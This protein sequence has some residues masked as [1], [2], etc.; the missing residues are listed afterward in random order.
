MTNGHTKSANDLLLFRVEHGFHLRIDA[1]SGGSENSSSATGPLDLQSLSQRFLRK[2]L[3]F[4]QYLAYMGSLLPKQYHDLLVGYFFSGEYVDDPVGL[5]RDTNVN[6]AELSILCQTL[7]LA[8]RLEDA[9]IVRTVERGI[10]ELT[11]AAFA[12]TKLRRIASVENLGQ[13]LVA[14][15]APPIDRMEELTDFS[16]ILGSAKGQLVRMFGPDLFTALQQVSDPDF[17]ITDAVAQRQLRIC[18][19]W[20]CTDL[21]AQLLL[22]RA[23]RDSDQ[24]N[25]PARLLFTNVTFSES[26]NESTR[27]LQKA[28]TS[29]IEHSLEPNT[30][31]ARS[32]SHICALRAAIDTA[33]AESVLEQVLSLY[34]LD[35]AIMEWLNWDDIY[36]TLRNS[37]RIE[38]LHSCAIHLLMG[39]PHVRRK[40]PVVA[41][42]EGEGAFE[43]S[44]RSA[45][46]KFTDKSLE[47]LSDGLKGISGRCRTLLVDAILD[48]DTAAALSVLLQ[49]NASWAK[50]LTNTR[51]L[52]YDIRASAV[53]SDLAKAF[54]K[55]Q[56][57]DKDRAQAI[58]G[59]EQ[60][61][62]RVAYLQGRQLDG[63]VYVDWRRIGESLDLEFSG[64]ID[65]VRRMLEEPTLKSRTR[66]CEHVAKELAERMTTLFLV[67]G[68]DNLKTTISDTLRHGQLLNRFMIAFDRAISHAAA[69]SLDVSALI[70][71]LSARG[72]WLIDLR[73]DLVARIHAF[74]ADC[75]TVWEP[76]NFKTEVF[77][78]FK[79]Q[80]EER[81]QS[82]KPSA[83]LSGCLQEIQNLLRNFLSQARRE[84][85][86]RIEQY[87]KHIAELSQSTKE[88]NFVLPISDHHTFDKHRFFLALRDNVA[89]AE[90]EAS[91]W[92]SLTDSRQDPDPF[93]FSDLVQF[94]LINHRPISGKQLNVTTTVSERRAAEGAV[95]QSTPPMIKGKYFVFLETAVKNLL[96]NALSHSGNGLQTRISIE[97]IYSKNHLTLSCRNTVSSARYKVLSEKLP[98]IEAMANS[99]NVSVAGNDKGSGLLK[100]SWAFKRALAT[101]PFVTLKFAPRGLVLQISFTARHSQGTIIEENLDHRR[102]T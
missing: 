94:C 75:L 54:A 44:L 79:R 41:F 56:L 86:T 16:Q 57:L 102:P 46:G 22:L 72:N 38:G 55:H 17:E 85:S 95:V 73:T 32:L 62:L 80:I 50:Q 42:A 34:N 59:E 12:R 43:S 13:L 88:S 48:S 89:E 51:S 31:L 1:L 101:F 25:D 37:T 99:G 2:D 8:D 6:D 45:V 49:H 76:S 100:V 40:F 14:C 52:A 83:P 96:S 9:D 60:S 65:L 3:P 92:I 30:K 84:L 21:L 69:T 7:V 74:N 23:T 61:R 78:V 4:S 15:G 36:R 87:Y 26:L 53:R 70:A 71:E 98:E 18:L 82:T 68:P 58:I 81:L 66:Y 33:D 90:Q 47:N 39:Q 29:K 11:R 64:P 19:D 24:C 93:Y 77:E 28:W 63:V 67:E 10:A 35:P 20:R 5:L 91:P 97:L 27:S